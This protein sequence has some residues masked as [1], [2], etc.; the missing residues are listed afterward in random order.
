MRAIAQD[1][2][3][4]PIRVA[5]RRNDAGSARDPP[6]VLGDAAE[7]ESPTKAAAAIF[8]TRMAPLAAEKLASSCSD[9]AHAEQPSELPHAAASIALG[10]RKRGPRAGP[11][12][13][14]RSGSGWPCAG[15]A[16]QHGQGWW[17]AERWSRS[18][19]WMTPVVRARPNVPD[20][21][22]S[23]A[24]RDDHCH[25]GTRLEQCIARAQHE[26][27]PTQRSREPHP[28]LVRNLG[29]ERREWLS[30]T[31]RQ[32]RM[33]AARSR[34]YTPRAS[35]TR[36]CCPPERL[37]PALPTVVLSESAR[38]RR[39]TSKPHAAMALWY[40]TASYERPK[41]MLSRTVPRKRT[42]AARSKP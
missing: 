17:E 10:L 13:L 11:L 23:S 12:P 35:A 14:S 37:P 19:R 41:T 5:P 25:L 22:P 9:K 31:N 33:S 28:Q 15:V 39:S 8:V 42:A 3:S 36:I 1:A 21:Q 32:S 6:S 16:R 30:A 27:G 4:A 2:A 24:H 38:R 7:A 34:A 20:L 18:W 40:A 29:V 26:R